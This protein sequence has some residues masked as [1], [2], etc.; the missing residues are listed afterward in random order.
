MKKFAPPSVQSAFARL[1]SDGGSTDGTCTIVPVE[2]D[3]AGSFVLGDEIKVANC[4]RAIQAAGEMSTRALGVLVVA[5]S[6]GKP[7]VLAR[8][9]ETPRDL[10]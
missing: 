3:E 8:Y 5:Y 9:G 10:I 6:E 4:A 2:R 1:F 7:L